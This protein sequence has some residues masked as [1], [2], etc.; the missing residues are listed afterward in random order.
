MATPLVAV[1]TAD[2]SRV[3][4]TFAADIQTNHEI[5]VDRLPQGQGI[6]Y[7]VTSTRGITFTSAPP[8]SALVWLFNGYAGTAVSTSVP[9][10]AT[11]ATIISDAAIELGLISADITD[12]FASTDPNI[13]QLLRFL[14][15]GGREIARAR[16]WTHLDRE[17]TFSTVSG[18]ANYALPSDFR[19]LIAQSGWN[20]T[21]VWPLGGPVSSQ[22][23]QY[24]KAS[25]VVGDISY[26]VRLWASQMYLNPTPTSTQTI[27]FE[28]LSTYWVKPSGQTS[29]TSETP[30]VA[31]D[32]ICFD[33]NL[34]VRKL[35]LDFL[36]AKGLD[37]TTAQIDFDASLDSAK[38]EDADGPILSLGGYVDP[39][40]LLSGDNFPQTGYGS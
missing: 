30:T 39:L 19:N 34:I 13:I 20:R 32:T 2:G 12:P 4:F 36:K 29:P 9:S 16:E 21:T 1:E 5:A 17:Y 35:K 11:V 40:H 7:T 37:T 14:K 18:T 22:D 10:W 27:A 38:G 6:D 23:W 8:S 24:R 3:A 26:A 33:P 25:P 28:Y 31:T 15:S